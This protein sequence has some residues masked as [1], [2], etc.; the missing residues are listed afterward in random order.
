L[1]NFILIERARRLVLGFAPAALLS[2][3][4]TPLAAQH[5]YECRGYPSRGV[6]RDIALRVE[7]MRRLERETADRLVGLDTRPYAWLL[8]QARKAESE[9]AVPALLEAE[10][11]LERCRNN[12]RPLR[13]ACAGAASAL[14]RVIEEILSAEAKPDKKPDVKKDVSQGDKQDDT[15]DDTKDDKKNAGSE[16]RKA[17]A[18][19]MPV[20][21]RA[22]SLA[23]LDTT[24]RHFE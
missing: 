4:S 10:K 21:E 18:Q 14:V 6:V 11:T 8:E 13:A 15:K 7:T 17:F 20:C 9:I 23:P 1:K 3:L 12:I 5:L 24:L 19:V 2:V 16:A 22:V